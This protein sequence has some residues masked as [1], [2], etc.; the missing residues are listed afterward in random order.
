MSVLRGLG[1]KAP[2]LLKHGWVEPRQAMGAVLW[3][4]HSWGNV[5]LCNQS[6]QSP[7]RLLSSTPA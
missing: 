4:C 2:V 3:S 5:C 6:P 1:F 7:A